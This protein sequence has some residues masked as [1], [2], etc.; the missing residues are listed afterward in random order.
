MLR[1]A[2]RSTG[3]TLFEYCIIVALVSI[4]AVIMLSGIGGVT[5][6]NL[7]PVQTGFQ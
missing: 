5:N 4:A 2:K 6:N 7:A 3:A 1:R